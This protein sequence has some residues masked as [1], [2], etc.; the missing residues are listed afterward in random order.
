MLLVQRIVKY[1]SQCEEGITFA[2]TDDRP[3]YLSISIDDLL[4][5][6][7]THIFNGAESVCSHIKPMIPSVVRGPKAKYKADNAVKA[8]Q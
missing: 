4:A 2:M 3:R 6:K 1:W 8:D 7:L 5:K